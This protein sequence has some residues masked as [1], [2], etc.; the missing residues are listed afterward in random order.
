M[1]LR[2]FSKALL[3]AY[4]TRAATRPMR[5]ALANGKLSSIAASHSKYSE[6]NSIAVDASQW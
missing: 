6:L 4:V 3:M 2:T 1:R 5:R